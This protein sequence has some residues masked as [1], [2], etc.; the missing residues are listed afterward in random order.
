MLS[1]TGDSRGRIH[2]LGRSQADNG[3]YNRV[4]LHCLRV[5]RVIVNAWRS[6]LAAAVRRRHPHLSALVFHHAAA[7]TLLSAHF[8]IWNHAGHCRSQARHEQQNQHTELAKNPHCHGLDYVYPTK[9][10]TCSFSTPS[11]HD[12]VHSAFSRYFLRRVLTVISDSTL[13][14]F[15]PGFRS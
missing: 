8:S 15:S 7:G 6:L 3:N 12:S 10:A 14:H 2:E 13:E 5:Q 1:P 9:G 11:A 4:K